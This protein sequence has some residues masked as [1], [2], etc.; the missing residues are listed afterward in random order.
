MALNREIDGTA[1][2]VGSTIARDFSFCQGFGYLGRMCNTLPVAAD[3]AKK[4]KKFNASDDEAG[5]VL[6]PG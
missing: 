2:C 3:N 6:D 5:R 1:T 4:I